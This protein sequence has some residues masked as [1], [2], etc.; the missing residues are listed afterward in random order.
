MRILVVEDDVLQSSWLERS[1]SEHGHEIHC[2]YD[3]DDALR[4]W[5][6]YRPDLVITDYRYPGKTIRNGLELVAAVRSIDPLQA[7][8]IQT[9]ERNLAAQFGVRVLW[10]PYSIHRLL[11]LMKMPVEPLLPLP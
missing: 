2:A 6:F 4:A 8:V 11:R 3:G 10:K 9:S 7:F 1:L 5:K